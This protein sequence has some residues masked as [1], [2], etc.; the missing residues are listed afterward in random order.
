MHYYTFTG[1]TVASFGLCNY[2]L[3]ICNCCFADECWMDIQMGIELYINIQ[4]FFRTHFICP[5]SLTCISIHPLYL[6][7][8]YSDEITVTM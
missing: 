2:N 6:I 5:S 7:C 3:K 4:M 8:V 1:K